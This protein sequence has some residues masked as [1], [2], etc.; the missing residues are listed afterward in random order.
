[1]TRCEAITRMGTG[2]T[3]TVTYSGGGVRLCDRHRIALHES[4]SLRL[5]NGRQARIARDI[6]GANPQVRV[7][8][9]GFDND[10][11]Q[12]LVA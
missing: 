3:G 9:V 1:M 5:T 8:R 10:K 4:F 12:E 2:C 6:T 11:R 7:A